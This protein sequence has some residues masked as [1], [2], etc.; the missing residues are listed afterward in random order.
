MSKRVQWAGLAGAGVLLVLAV[1]GLSQYGP[2]PPQPPQPPPT[3]TTQ[4]S[5]V[6]LTAT[7]TATQEVPAPAVT[8]AVVGAGVFVFDPTTNTLS[9]SIAY[10]GLSGG[11]IAAHFH[12]GA[13]GAAGPVVQTICGP[14]AQTPTPLLGACPAGTSGFLTGTWAVPATLVPTLLAGGLYVN[15]HTPLNSAGEIRGQITPL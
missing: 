7:V 12:N 9:F 14:P 2:Q 11:A 3:T 5:L 1:Y 4:L 6:V 8:T 15:V 13:A 10:R